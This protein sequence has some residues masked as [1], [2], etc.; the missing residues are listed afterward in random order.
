MYT[1]FVDIKSGGTVKL[2][3]KRVFLE[4]SEAEAVMLFERIFGID[5]SNV[6]CQCCGADYLVVESNDQPRERD[7]V[8]NRADI[9]RFDAG[10]KLTFS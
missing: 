8:V 7:W 4:A 1:Q 3:A 10:R 9:Q 6:T 2:G 5:P